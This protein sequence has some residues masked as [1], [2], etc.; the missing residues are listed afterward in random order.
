MRLGGQTT[1]LDVWDV[2]ECSV[3]AAISDGAVDGIS[4]TVSMALTGCSE[5]PRRFS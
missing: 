4:P 1:E 2:L 5:Y 3:F